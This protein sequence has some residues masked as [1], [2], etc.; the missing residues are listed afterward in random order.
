MFWHRRI[1]RIVKH[2]L[3]AVGS[4]TALVAVGIGCLFAYASI[5]QEDTF[6]LLDAEPSDPNYLDTI[7]EEGHDGSRGPERFGFAIHHIKAGTGVIFG[8]RFYSNGV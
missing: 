1:V 8:Y 5:D 6:Y 3:I 7:N 2:I 4:L